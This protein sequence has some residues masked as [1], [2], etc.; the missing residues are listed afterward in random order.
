[1]GGC[2]ERAFTQKAPA[3]TLEW[4]NYSVLASYKVQA[5]KVRRQVRTRTYVGRLY[6]PGIYVSALDI[7]A[8]E[9]PFSL[10]CF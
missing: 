10:I 5:S 8:V 6:N 2:T 7:L 3:L 4:D 9:K 1:M